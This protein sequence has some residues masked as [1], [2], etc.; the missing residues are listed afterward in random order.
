MVSKELE[1][2]MVGLFG[3]IWWLSLGLVI[4]E[5][6][7]SVDTLQMDLN[8]HPF[9]TFLFGSPCPW[10][11]PPSLLS[12]A[13]PWGWRHTPIRGSALHQLMDHLPPCLSKQRWAILSQRLQSV[14]NSSRR[15]EEFTICLSYNDNHYEWCPW[16]TRIVRRMTFWRYNQVHFCFCLVWS[17]PQ[18]CDL[19]LLSSSYWGNWEK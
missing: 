5:D 12:R 3:G 16:H 15:L 9:A 11:S 10:L 7:E 17:P 14:S 8:I 13:I 2:L 4:W 18:R 6:C 19:V 1:T